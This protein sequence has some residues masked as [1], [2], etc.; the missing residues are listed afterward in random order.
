MNNQNELQK[1]ENALNEEKI[2]QFWRDNNIFQKTLEKEAPKGDLVF[3]DGPPFATGLPHYGHILGGTGK[4]VFA[5]Y[6]TMRGFRV[7]R[8]W[9]WDTHGLPIET[10]VEKSLGITSKKQIEEMG[11]EKFSQEARSK[12]LGF[13]HDWKKTVERTA[14]WVDFDGSY[15][16]MDTTYI[17]SV[18]WALGQ[19]QEKGIV[20]E[21]DRIL[22][23]C[24]RCQTP[25]A[26]A[27]I[28]MDNSYK[29]IV[30]IS[31]YVKM[32]LA[33][34]ENEY[35]LAWTT[36]PWTLPGNAALA[37][38][39]ELTYIKV[40][41]EHGIYYLGKDRVE[42]V[43]KD[44]EYEI[45][46]EVSGS[47]LVER[48]YIPPFDY[49]RE[50]YRDNSAVW[51]IYAGEF[52]TADT[53]TGI[54]HIAPSFG[55]DDAKLAK[56]YGIP[57]IK[58]VA[59]D[60]TFIPAVTHF[61]GV[62][63]KPKDDHQAA[64]VE[65]I[66][67]LAHNH[68]L[69]AKEKITH[70]YPHCYRCETPLLYYGLSSWF[71]NIQGY[72]KRMLELNESID[73]VP[74][75]LQHG[76]FQYV[77]E[78]APDW[79]FS[80]N[81][82]WASP[83]PIWKSQDGDVKFISSIEEMKKYTKKSG[84]KYFVMRH[85]EGFNNTE[86]LHK[87]ELYRTAMLTDEGKKQVTESIGKFTEKI[88]LVIS[89]PFER[90]KETAEIV[91]KHLNFPF[92]NVVYD[93]R[94]GEWATSSK[95]ENAPKEAFRQYYNI[96]YRK[97]PFI[98]LPE[99]ESF[100]DA[101]K[102][103][104]EFIYDLESKYKN[105]NIF[106]VGHS[107]MMRALE[108]AVNGYSFSNILDENILI[109]PGNAEIRV[110]DFVPLPHNE[111]YELDLHRP[112]IDSIKLEI[113]GREYIRIP[114]VIDCWF[115]SGSMP[116]AQDHYP[117]EKADWKEKNFPADFV[118]EY[119]AQT[120][121]WFYY[122]LLISTILFDAAPFKH[123]VTTGNLNGTDGQKMSKSKG[124]YP[125]PWI[126]IDKYGVDVL[127]F[128][129]MSSP[130]M[131]GEDSNFDEKMVD[132][133]NKKVF[134]ILRNV[135]SFYEMYTS[136]TDVNPADS[137][138]VLDQWILTL[139]AKLIQESTEGLDHYDVLSPARAIRDFVGE[140]STWYIRR[141]R[142]RFKSED[143]TDR[144]FAIATTKHVLIELAKVVAPFTPFIAEEIWQ[145]IVQDGSSVHLQE[146][147]KLE[148]YNNTILQEMETVRKIVTL[149]LEAR[150][151]TN[152]KVR[153]PLESLSIWKQPEIILG[154]ELIEEEI[155][156][157]KLVFD[158]KLKENEVFL[159]TEI[160]DD[161]RD[162][163]DMRE[164]VRKIQDMRKTA[165]LVPSDRVIVSLT[166]A[167]PVWYTK[168]QTEVLKSVGAEEIV[169]GSEHEK[170]EKQ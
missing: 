112:Y 123:V 103:V 71:I 29:D 135:V 101:V 96:D 11:I 142:D 107:G 45:V 141:S 12:V 159:N 140:L 139:L 125:D 72:K 85:G 106:I 162:E 149:G 110:F 116:F 73:W 44:K 128:Y 90:T 132:E 54:V 83:L 146:F 46:G 80:R 131:K 70:S 75:H 30:D 20:Y 157:K 5:R 1:S 91:C 144:N 77:L 89:S 61:A 114:E 105:K 155:N 92:E 34:R 40:S 115:E 163:G 28:A 50:Q 164:L 42:A 165:D 32:Q 167:E 4:D 133:L 126:I 147:P 26:N 18:W 31:V 15:K 113:D 78:N 158:P 108:F 49:F 119:I 17:E 143:V 52:V 35:V 2:L 151:K 104:G 169:W 129:L 145:S 88:D 39:P 122:M 84:N 138:N 93:D 13:V 109:P 153:Q 24:P 97:E 59:L 66:K 62:Q 160:T 95:F 82:F 19:M 3:Y 6:Q 33:D 69:F 118:V 48:S 100:A 121:T 86:K 63:V 148:N 79:N 102:R 41:F 60:G 74:E 161:L 56:Q 43:F 65:I 36:T 154:S 64:D 111:N 166:E 14:R 10:I 124:N 7:P 170:V 117:F 9:G 22:P 127:R 57:A 81:R 68:L 150:S 27:E 76:R 55:E 136:P 67:Y 87:Q 99:G 21:A 58:H 134:N 16:T 137:P 8:K 156:V 53:G 47:E 120:R 38:N 152:I 98:T 37:V 23:Y 130:L 25:L 168:L 94:A 51:K